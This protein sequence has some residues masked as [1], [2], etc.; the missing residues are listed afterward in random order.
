MTDPEAVIVEE[1]SPP[2]G[3]TDSGSDRR[4]L[5]GLLGLEAASMRG[6][7]V[8]LGSYEVPPG[9]IAEVRVGGLGNVYL[10]SSPAM[11]TEV[12]RLLT[13]H[14]FVH[15]VQLQN[16][17][18]TLVNRAT[19]GTTDGRYAA[20]ATTE[21]AAVVATDAVLDRYVPGGPRNS[22]LYAGVADAVPPGSANAYGNGRYVNGAAYVAGRVD[23]P[24]NLSRVYEHPPTTSEQ[25]LH[26]V[27]P[28]VEP[29]ANLSVT[30]ATDGEYVVAGTDRKGEAYVRHALAN[31]VDWDRAR[32]AAAGWGNDTVRTL[33]PAGG[34]NLSYV[35]IQRWDDADE[36][37]E[38]AAAAADYLDA[39]G[40]TENGTATLNGVPATLRTPGD[41]TTALVIGPEPLQDRT[42]VAVEGQRVVVETG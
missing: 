13:T 3:G 1:P 25:V 33:Q 14:E 37:S 30:V 18:F 24:A 20:R 34:G 26:G 39:R 23:D 29:P 32:A 41:R 6:T 15:Y 27:A 11:P 8:S 5:A 2:A 36:A 21:G 9:W 4:T 17:R 7:N 40:A 35:W 12:V 10:R 42:S 19:D 22:E 31:G 38:F 28:G 16:D